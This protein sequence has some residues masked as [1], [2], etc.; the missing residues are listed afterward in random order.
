[1]TLI[2]RVNTTR[3]HARFAAA[4]AGALPRG[5]SHPRAS[6]ASSGASSGSSAAPRNRMDEVRSAAYIL[7]YFTHNDP[8][9]RSTALPLPRSPFPLLF[10]FR[11]PLYC[12]RAS[13]TPRAAALEQVA[14]LVRASTSVASA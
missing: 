5:V 1:M 8:S 12:R 10:N 13:T 7:C 6:A 11:Y 9:S 2:N 4:R 14:V 3:A